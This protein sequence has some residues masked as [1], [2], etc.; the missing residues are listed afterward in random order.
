M[1]IQVDTFDDSRAVPAGSRR[2]S[3]TSDEERATAT[4][5]VTLWIS[6]TVE[7]SKP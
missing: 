1:N 6:A 5:T 2:S 4:Q 3:T 7:M